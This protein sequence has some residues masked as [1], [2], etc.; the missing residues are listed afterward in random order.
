VAGGFREID[1]TINNGDAWYDGLQVNLNKRFGRSFSLLLSYTYSHSIDTAEPDSPSENPNDQTQ[2]GSSYEKA[3]GSLD[4]RNRAVLTGWD[5]LPHGMSVGASASL[6]PG[7]PYNVTTGVDNNGDGVSADRP[8]INGA[9]IGRNTGLGTQLYDLSVFF[10]KG[11]TFGERKQL[12]LRGEAFNLLNHSNF[13]SRSGVFGNGAIA[14]P[15][16]GTPT[17]GFSGVEP[18]REFQFSAHFRF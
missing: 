2:L 12:S 11:F 17:G 7:F 1:A 13:I 10:E 14:L 3:T 8:V 5:Q 4:Q 6:G 16:F 9:V 18:G 15:T